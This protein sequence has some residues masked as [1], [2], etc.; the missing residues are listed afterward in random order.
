MTWP[1]ISSIVNEL[2]TIELVFFFLDKFFSQIAKSIFAQNKIET[3]KQD[4]NW[5]PLTRSFTILK[6]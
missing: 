6:E 3:A 2:G 1:F 5:T 4:D